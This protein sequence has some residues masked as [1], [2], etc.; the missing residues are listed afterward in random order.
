MGRRSRTGAVAVL[1]LGALEGAA[2]AAN[3][4][5]EIVFEATVQPNEI[6]SLQTRELGYRLRMTT[7]GRHERFR[8]RVEQPVWD[9]VSAWRPNGLAAVPDCSRRPL[10]LRGRGRLTDTACEPRPARDPGCGRGGSFWR[11]SG[12]V[13]LPA[14]STST[15]VARFLTAGP[16]LLRTDYRASFVVGGGRNDT[17]TGVQRIRPPTPAVLGPFG[18]HITLATRPG[19][20]YFPG[21]RRF[22]RGTTI[23]IRGRAERSLAGEMIRLRYTYLAPRGASRQLTFARVRIDGR[24]RFGYRGWRPSRPGSYRLYAAY[25]PRSRDRTSDQSCSRGLIVLG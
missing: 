1:L 11:L 2:V 10:V 24:G 17:L 23:N 8:V 12:E 7:G 20:P 15:L 14:H 19:T 18:A 3:V 6:S 5:A 16:P 22:R 4:R 21:R 13:A 25:R 9:P